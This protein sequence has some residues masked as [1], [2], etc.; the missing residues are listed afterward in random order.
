MRI[1]AQARSLVRRLLG[2]RVLKLV[3]GARRPRVRNLNL[4]RSLLAGKRGL[5]IGG[6]SEVF[7][8]EGALP[9][10]SVVEGLN[11]CLFSGH[12][13][14]E[15]K[16]REGRTYTFHPS[17]Q[18]GL[19]FISEGTTLQSVSDS[20]Y[21]C[22][23]SSHSLE[24]MANPLRALAEWKR[25]LHKE[26]LL[27][28]VLPH[29]EGTFDWRRPTTSLAHLMEDFENN[30]GEGDLTHLPEILHLHDLEKDKAA[31]SME[32]FRARCSDNFSNRAM[33][34]HVFD[35]ASAVVMLDKAAFQVICV[36]AVN[37]CHIILLSRRSEVVPDNSTFLAGTAEYHRHSPFLIDRRF[38]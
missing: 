33:H 7:G 26:G 25:I 31:G 11:N 15:G 24:H 29:K 20:S 6:P 16:V 9:I 35:T 5:E 38:R 12:T 32:Q 34:H 2:P 14:W 1:S 19:Q 27:L 28:L 13:I 21:D 17:K 23:L 10:Y 37:P 4:Y 18:P 30:T 36:D 22:V 3:R 8:D